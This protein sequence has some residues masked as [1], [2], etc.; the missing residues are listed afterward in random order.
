MRK[1]CSKV[2]FN[3]VINHEIHPANDRNP[4]NEVCAFTTALLQ[5]CKKGRQSIQDY[6]CDTY[7]DMEICPFAA[8]YLQAPI[9]R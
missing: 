3:T 8:E 5:S 2:L 4:R 7:P 9:T 6:C 1:K